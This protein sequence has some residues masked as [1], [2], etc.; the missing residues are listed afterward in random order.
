M[1]KSGYRPWFALRKK[2][3]PIHR[4]WLL[5]ALDNR[6]GHLKDG[7]DDKIYL[8]EGIS[9]TPTLLPSRDL[10]IHPTLHFFKLRRNG[11]WYSIKSITTW[12]FQCLNR[13]PLDLQTHTLTT[14]HG[15]LNYPTLPSYLKNHTTTTYHLNPNTHSSMQY[16]SYLRWRPLRIVWTKLTGDFICPIHG[17]RCF[18]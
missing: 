2:G 7:D 16:I 3:F 17:I 6:Y 5:S 4:Y 10:S 13:W 15:Y 8:W 18:A 12:D 1:D 14:T 9:P 11:L